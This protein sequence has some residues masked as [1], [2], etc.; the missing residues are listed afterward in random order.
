MKKF[1]NILVVSFFLSGIFSFNLFGQEICM[2]TADF[3]D[4][5]KFVVIW[6]KPAVTTGIDSVIIYRKKGA[7]TVF[8]RIGARSMQDDFSFFVDEGSSTIT[9]SWYRI[10]YLSTTGI[11]SAPS[12]WHSPVI[13]DFLDGLLVWTLYEKEDQ[14]DP[15][16]VSGYECLRDETG[17]GVYTSMGYWWTSTGGAQT[18]WLDSEAASQQNFVYQMQMDLPACD[19][20]K[21]NINTSRSNI[22][23]MMSNEEEEEAQAG[24]GSVYSNM[25]FALSPNPAQENIRIEL[26]EQLVGS[27]FM[28]T[29]STGKIMNRGQLLLHEQLL[30][31]DQLESGVYFF[32]IRFEGKNFSRTFIKN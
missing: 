27:D 5:K 31:I 21:S 18:E 17:L 29:N 7:E 3:D 28:I 32:T 13:L 23:G 12:P 22:K 20:T 26:D 10:A 8:T 4:A 16:W 11:E 6:E 9:E 2:V 15:S 14:L 25:N 30:D 19:I 1:N 24:I